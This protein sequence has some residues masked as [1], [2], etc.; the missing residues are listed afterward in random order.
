MMSPGHHMVGCVDIKQMSDPT[1]LRH[2]S[3]RA[4]AAGADWKPFRAAVSLHAHTHHSRE[5]L[6]DLPAYIRR[7]P[8]V[9]ARFERQ[10]EARRAQNQNVDFTKGWWHPPV[11][12]REVFESEARQIDRRFDP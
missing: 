9:G 1:L 7:I 6:S 10:L 12:P 3:L 2:T 5:V 4:F 11:S 8:I